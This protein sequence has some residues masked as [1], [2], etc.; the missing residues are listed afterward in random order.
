MGAYIAMTNVS[1]DR[2]LQR[3]AFLQRY[4]GALGALQ[5]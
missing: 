5:R 4:G 1:A 3:E 2:L